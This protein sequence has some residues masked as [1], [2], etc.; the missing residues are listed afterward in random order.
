MADELVVRERV[1]DYMSQAVSDR[2][3]NIRC[4]VVK[5]ANGG[6]YPPFWYSAV[7]A[8]GLMD[9]TLGK[10]KSELRIETVRRDDDNW[11]GNLGGVGIDLLSVP[12]YEPTP[13][14]SDSSG[15]SSGDWGG[16]GGGESGG[17]GSSDSF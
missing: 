17:G 8:S 2:D 5:Q 7:I 10:G 4:E 3:W 14:S 16:F 12:V 15:S 6:G 11:A 13:S 1:I 9:R